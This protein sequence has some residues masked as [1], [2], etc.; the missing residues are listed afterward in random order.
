MWKLVWRCIKMAEPIKTRKAMKTM[1]TIFAALLLGALVALAAACGPRTGK[2]AKAQTPVTGVVETPVTKPATEPTTEPATEP[3]T[4]PTVEPVGEPRIEPVAAV[5]IRYKEPDGEV[6][7]KIEVPVT[8]AWGEAPSADFHFAS[9][10]AMFA[11]LLRGSDFA[12]MGTYALVAEQARLGLGDDPNGYRREMVRLAEV[13]A[14]L[15]VS[16]AGSVVTENR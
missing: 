3:A 4:E 16:D 11:Q 13:A 9:A 2:S 15:S 10:A 5:K 8:D 6:N 7:S 14:G 12:G 1:R